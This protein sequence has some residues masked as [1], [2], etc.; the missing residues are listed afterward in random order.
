MVYDGYD[1]DVDVSN[2]SFEKVETVSINHF[3]KSKLW[4]TLSHRDNGEDLI[5][6]KISGINT[7]NNSSKTTRISGNSYIIEW[8]RP[9]FHTMHDIVGEY[10]LIKEVIPDL[11]P[12]IIYTGVLKDP[13]AIFNAFYGAILKK[14][15][16]IKDLLEMIEFDYRNFF[17]VDGK[18]NIVIDNLYSISLYGDGFKSELFYKINEKLGNNFIL[19]KNDASYAYRF[20]VTFA[21]KNFF[22]SFRTNTVP[23]RKIFV[24]TKHK[25][26]MLDKAKM[27]YDFLDSNGV[28]WSVDWRT[29]CNTEKV[30]GLDLSAF[31]PAQFN[32]GVKDANIRYISREEEDAMEKYFESQGFEIITID[33]TSLKY[34]I[35]LMSEASVVAVWAGASELQSLF[36][37]DDS[38]FIYVAPRMEYGFPH[39]DIL[40]VIKPDAKIF[41]DKR[42]PE[43]YGKTF[44]SGT[45]IKAVDKV[46]REIE[47]DSK[48]VR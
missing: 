9:F 16:F 47:N 45:I 6:Y 39:E 20:A 15:D 12:V 27:L 28:K 46:L 26:E 38:T 25:R 17:F 13:Q 48:K 14:P 2:S 32:S 18:D 4:E 36:V 43:N 40:E 22:K 21:M 31:L 34:Q 19:P 5:F 1:Y 8:N 33:G 41:F 30:D 29:P 7:N 23:Y 42:M 24:S 35:G 10:L 37:Q 44:D 11:K 3:K